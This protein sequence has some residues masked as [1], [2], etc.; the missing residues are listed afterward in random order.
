MKAYVVLIYL[1]CF[2]CG[3]IAE[4]E[5]YS[6]GAL[7]PIG[8]SLFAPIQIDEPN[9]HAQKLYMRSAPQRVEGLVDAKRFPIEVIL[10]GIAI[11]MAYLVAVRI[12]PVPKIEVVPPLTDGER[13]DLAQKIIV[14][15]GEELSEE[16]ALSLFALLD[17][18]AESLSDPAKYEHIAEQVKFAGATLRKEEFDEII[19]KYVS[20]ST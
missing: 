14:E 10:I 20:Y 8:E 19:P 18:V 1:V 2:F 11:G 7:P 9:T 15:A 5:Q 12:R 4:E 16:E 3:L 17:P 13:L 6:V